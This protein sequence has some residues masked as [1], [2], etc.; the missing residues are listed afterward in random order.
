MTTVQDRIG[1]T[2]TGQVDAAVAAVT[3]TAARAQS[4]D[5]TQPFYRTGLGV[6]VTGGVADWLPV[7]RTFLSARFIQAIGALLAIALS[8]GILVWLF[9][10]HSPLIDSS[11]STSSGARNALL[12]GSAMA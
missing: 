12:R 4:S 9:E 3:V 6:A 11:N 7:L 10:H 8:V 5:F 1:A 2:S